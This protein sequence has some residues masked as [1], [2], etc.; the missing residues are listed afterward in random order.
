M[1]PGYLMTNV[2]LHGSAEQRHCALRSLAVDH[3][4]SS[5][6]IGLSAMINSGQSPDTSLEMPSQNGCVVLGDA[7]GTQ[8]LPGRPVHLSDRLS[9]DD[10]GAYRLWQQL[11][12]VWD[13]ALN[14]FSRNSLDGGG[15]VVV[16]TLRYG[17]GYDNVMWDGRR[18]ILG[19]GD[20]ITFGPVGAGVDVVAHELAH[21]IT[22]CEAGLMYWAQAGALQ[23]SL[24]D[25]FAT[26]VKQYV[27]DESVDQADWL[28]GREVF[29]PGIDA[30]A[31][32]SLADPGSAYDDAVLGRDPQPS[33][34]SGYVHGVE[35]N[36]GIH[37][38][39]GIPNRA[40][41]LAATNIGGFSWEGA[42]LIWYAALTSGRLERGARFSEFATLT[43]EQAA[44]LFPG[45]DAADAVADAWGQ[46]GLPVGTERTERQ[47][48][49]W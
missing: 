13:F 31:L 19:D 21:A 25:V 20:G 33:T 5:A 3:A 43:V 6:R 28:V 41:Y 16:S 22:S 23:E 42:G 10:P 27:A 11:T 32:R 46:V 40:F 15:M 2:A 47:G 8:R 34:M 39:S 35:D 48:A 29:A 26:Q 7:G 1:I 12:E 9:D 30:D 44:R 45:S 37:I 49:T 4:L 17:E 36:G 18:L 14:A 38:N 24:A